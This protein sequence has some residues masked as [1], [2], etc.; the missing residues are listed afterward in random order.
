M[1]S[2]WI[3]VSGRTSDE[4]GLMHSKQV[5]ERYE[6]KEAVFQHNAI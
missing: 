2:G 1:N 5:V 3:L 6:A 4:R